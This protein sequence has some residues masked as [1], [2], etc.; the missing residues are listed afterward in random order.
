M[1]DILGK[2]DVFDSGA[3]GDRGVDKVHSQAKAVR[4]ST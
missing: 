2:E 3:V 4:T 1:C